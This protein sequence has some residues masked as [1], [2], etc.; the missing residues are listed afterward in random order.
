[1]WI[2]GVAAGLCASTG[3][4]AWGVRGRSSRLFGPS[5]WR[6][7]SARPALAFTF[8]DGP[9]ESTPELLEVLGR[10]G[11]RATFFQCGVHVR[12][13]PQVAR[14]VASGG[15]EIGNHTDTHARL[16]LR[17]AGFIRQELRRGQEAIAEATGIRPKLFRAPYGVRWFGLRAAQRELNLL[18][19]M[20][21]TIGRDWKR[22]AEAVAARLRA[23]AANGAIFCLHDGRGVQVRPDI[24]ATIGAVRRL[25]PELRD[26][27]YHFGSVSEIICPKN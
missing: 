10:Y 18:G 9:S 19:V 13:L 6:G 17:S 20:W 12:R 22:P 16:Y 23:A 2:E 26:K 25:L 4:M 5:V 7:A 27:G 24:A 1:M 11:A 8:D 3:L 14:E 15:H 21:T